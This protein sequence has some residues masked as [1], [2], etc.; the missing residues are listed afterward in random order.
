VAHE[1]KV[2]VAGFASKQI[3]QIETSSLMPKA[4][5]LV[6]VS[7]SNYRQSD[8]EVYRYGFLLQRLNSPYLYLIII[9]DKV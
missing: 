2:I 6:G 7:L 9:L 4:F 8:P 1:G 5:N 3:P